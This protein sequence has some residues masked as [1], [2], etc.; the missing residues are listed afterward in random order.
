MKN[1]LL[2]RKYIDG[3][4]RVKYYQLIVPYAMR[5]TMLQNIHAG[6]SQ[7]HFGVNKS[8]KMFIRFAYWSGWKADLERHVRMCEICCRYRRGPAKRQGLMQPQPACAPM[9]KLHID[10]TG[11][12]VKSNGGFV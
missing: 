1:G 4:G 2:Y 12:H 11:P 10:L 6:T 9:Q 7:G 3:E 5:T 8:A